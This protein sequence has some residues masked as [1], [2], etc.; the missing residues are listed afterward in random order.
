MYSS[1]QGNQLSDS[2]IRKFN[3]TC[4]DG[5]E[6]PDGFWSEITNER[7]DEVYWLVYRCIHYSLKE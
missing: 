2:R 3:I 1:E 5:T 4:T 6:I 7:K